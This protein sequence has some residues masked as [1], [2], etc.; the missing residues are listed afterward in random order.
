MQYN[1]ASLFIDRNHRYRVF[2]EMKALTTL[3]P[4][5]DVPG[6]LMLDEP[7]ENPS[8]CQCFFSPFS[9]LKTGVYLFRVWVLP[10]FG[11][12]KKMGLIFGAPLR[13]LNLHRIALSQRGERREGDR[14]R[15]LG[16]PD[17]NE[18]VKTIETVE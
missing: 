17:E 10:V 11:K 15:A 16:N 18:T 9:F 3:S 4:P 5:G 2:V 1:D 13:S 8:C 7:T 12:I 6:F 14:S